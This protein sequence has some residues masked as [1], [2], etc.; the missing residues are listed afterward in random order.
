M[1]SSAI[2]YKEPCEREVLDNI[3]VFQVGDSDQGQT[4]SSLPMLKWS[5]DSS[6]CFAKLEFPFDILHVQSPD[7][8][9]ECRSFVPRPKDIL[10]ET[11]Q[12]NGN[13]ITVELPPYGCVSRSRQ[14]LEMRAAD[15]MKYDTARFTKDI[16]AFMEALQ[17][18]VERELTET[19]PGEIMR[20]TVAEAQRYS[21]LN[22]VGLSVVS[23]PC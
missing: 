12:V 9:I 3:M 6:A 14:T 15:H 1:A 18:L 4:R 5:A 13:I 23:I 21:S 17:P 10:Y 8:T 11:F 16:S 20:L 7:L 19:I 22:Q 2:Q